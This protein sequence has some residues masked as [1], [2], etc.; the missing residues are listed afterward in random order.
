[1]HDPRRPLELSMRTAHA[2]AETES[3]TIRQAENGGGADA[4]AGGR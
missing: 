1:M 3:T 2:K 4:E